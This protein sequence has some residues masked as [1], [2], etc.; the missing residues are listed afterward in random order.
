MR[1]IHHHLSL[2]SEWLHILAE[3]LGTKVTDDKIIHFP[4]KI[5]TGY[6]YF[7]KITPGI[8]VFFIDLSL[9][10]PLK[11]TRESSSNE[12]FIFHYELSEHINLIKIN[13][14]DF[15][16]GSFDQLDLAIIDNEITSAYKP[17]LDQRTFAVRILVNK[18]LLTDFITKYPKNEYKSDRKN[19]SPEAFYHYGNIDSNSAL[20]LK[21]VK[22]KNINDLSF[23][24]FLK[25]I[26]LKLL[27]NF[28]SKFYDTENKNSTLTLVENDAIN[29][30]RDYLLANLYGP[31]PSVI[32]LA[33]MAGMSESKYKM[34]FKKSLSS[35][36]NNFFIK[37]KMTLGR[38]LLRSGEFHTLT[39]VMYELNYSKL[40]YFSSKYFEIFNCKPVDDFIKKSH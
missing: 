2:S 1:K 14:E 12:L 10:I 40:S 4:E 25:G 24:P 11:I 6:V 17:S 7:T 19:R 20:L 38:K 30:T 26:S 36:P 37:E 32:F 18:N 23:D 28:F 15:K 31:F 39:E 35:T 3:Q 34:T 5:G 21:S 13:N 8:S 29:K 22:T 16:I 9:K 27:G 33:A